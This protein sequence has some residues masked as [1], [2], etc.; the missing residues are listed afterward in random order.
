[1]DDFC[2]P[3]KTGR[4]PV[5]K[6]RG[7]WQN[8]VKMETLGSLKIWNRKVVARK[9]CV[10]RKKI[11]FEGGGGNGKIRK[12]TEAPHKKNKSKRKV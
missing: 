5:G 1:M 2:V 12:R 6:K 7:R 10:W 8:G 9:R 11:G 4:R 3:N